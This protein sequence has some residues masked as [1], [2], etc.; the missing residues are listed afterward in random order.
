MK[1]LMTCTAALFS[2]VG[3]CSAYASN[4]HTDVN[5]TNSTVNQLAY[6]VTCSDTGQAGAPVLDGKSA[7]EFTI[8]TAIDSDVNKTYHLTV[9]GFNGGPVICTFKYKLT[10]NGSGNIKPKIESIDNKYPSITSTTTDYCSSVNF[11]KT[12]DT[13]GKISVT[14]ATKPL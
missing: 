2:I 11:T 3:A 6:Y 1:R 12:S 8:S 7:K 13:Q 10:D 9:L 5:L 4:L 14:A